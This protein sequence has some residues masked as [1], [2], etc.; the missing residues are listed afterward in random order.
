MNRL[1]TD[2]QA[3]Y[4]A[5]LYTGTD[6]P[7]LHKA[8]TMYVHDLEQR[9]AERGM[10]I[11]W[12]ER[13]ICDRNKTI[14]RLE[15]ERDRIERL[16]YRF[17]DHAIDRFHDYRMEQERTRELGLTVHKLERKLS[18]ANRKHKAL[19]RA[20]HEDTE[21]VRGSLI[22]AAERLAQS[23]ITHST[24]EESAYGAAWP[25]FADGAP[26]AIGDCVKG[27]MCDVEVASIVFRADCIVLYD[28]QMF[29]YVKLDGGERAQ[30][31]DGTRLALD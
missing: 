5:Q 2:E 10:T 8:P 22:K 18:R 27:V 23:I 6:A 4:L 16:A 3:A 17:R 25:R 26:V 20:M 13:T 24:V 30:R 31:P 28:S 29:H 1:L 14:E 11:Q 7:K 12:L 9:Y 19:H 15:V 21:R